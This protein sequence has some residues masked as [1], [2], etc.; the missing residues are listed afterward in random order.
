[1]DTKVGKLAALHTGRPYPQEINLVL[2][3]FRGWV[4]P[5]AIVASGRIKTMENS[6]DIIGNRTRDLAVCNAVPRL[7]F[8]LFHSLIFLKTKRD[9]WQVGFAS[10]LRK[11]SCL[12]TEVGCRN[13]L[14]TLKIF[15]TWT[16]SKKKLRL[17]QFNYSLWYKIHVHLWVKFYL[18]RAISLRSGK[19]RLFA[20]SYLSPS[21]L[22]SVGLEKCEFYKTDFRG[23]VCAVILYGK[24]PITGQFSKSG[25]RT[26][27]REYNAW[28]SQE[29]LSVYRLYSK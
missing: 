10:V 13:V 3:S 16:K 2:L 4:D 7:N 9:V 11:F 12:K 18:L 5:R 22:L 20:L 17:C 28:W 21:V 14:L 23:I 26:P 19:K 29:T 1:M 8:G 15:R 27:P 24:S 6:K 25:A